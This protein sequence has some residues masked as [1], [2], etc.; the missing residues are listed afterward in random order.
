[1]SK[2]SV[3]IP[4]YNV[5]RYIEEC[6][7]SV[8]QQTLPAYEIICVNDGSTD[9]TLSILEQQRS[10]V[11]LNFKII[12]VKN[13]GAA[14]ARNIGLAAATGDYIQFLD[15]DDIIT[16][17]KF[18]KQIGGFA[19]DADMVVS[20]RI[21]KN[22]DLSAVIKEFYFDE[23]ERNPLETSIIKI[24]STCNPLY[25][26]SVVMELGGYDESLRSSQDWDFHIRLVLRGF[27][28]RYVPGVF[29]INRLVEGSVSSNWVKVSIEACRVVRNLKQPLAAHPMLN[30]K[31]RTHLAQIHFNSAIYCQDTEM[32]EELVKEL[33]YWSPAGYPF[34]HSRLKRLFANIFG[35][36]SLVMILR[37]QKLK[38][39]NVII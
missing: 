11:K 4:C 35:I 37:T 28:I 1:M 24:I 29:F 18:E 9:S 26:K 20:D 15:A 8:L 12:D 10:K 23:I 38:Q 14:K 31:A 36:R 2:I 13:G 7:D 19:A 6:I 34:I 39:M 5:E 27:K 16:P 30:D 21:Q 17:D 33:K 32:S 22:I 3:I 25:R